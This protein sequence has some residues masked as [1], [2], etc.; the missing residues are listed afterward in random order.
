M[1]FSFCCYRGMTSPWQ[2]QSL[3]SLTFLSILFQEMNW[4]LRSGRWETKTIAVVSVLSLVWF[5]SLVKRELIKRYRIRFKH[6]VCASRFC[7]FMNSSFQVL[8][9]FYGNRAWVE[10]YRSLTCGFTEVTKTLLNSS[11]TK[12]CQC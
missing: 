12:Y 11:H 2:L 7:M 9:F 10:I 4:N 6:E 8:K 3:I 5:E 1:V